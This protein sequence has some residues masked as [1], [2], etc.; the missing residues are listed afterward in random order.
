[1]CV[2]HLFSLRVE[3][4]GCYFL[5]S[6]LE[7]NIRRD[8]WEG[9]YVFFEVEDS[10]GRVPYSCPLRMLSDRGRWNEKERGREERSTFLQL[11]GNNYSRW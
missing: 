9:G 1:M 5:F 11:F 8:P 10:H 3:G 6:N 4:D 7:G 2:S